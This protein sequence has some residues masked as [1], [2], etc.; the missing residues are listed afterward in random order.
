MKTGSTRLPFRAILFDLDNTLVELIDAKRHACGMVTRF[1]GLEDNGELF[2]YFRRAVHHFESHEHLRDYLVDR[3]L[4]GGDLFLRCMHIHE[5]EKLDHVQAYD[6]VAET[7]AYLRERGF[8]LA[9]VT[10]AYQEGARARL[11]RT[12]LLGYVDQLVT[13]EMTGRKK[14]DPSPFLLALELLE[15]LPEEAIIV[16]DS[17]R[18]EIAPGNQLGIV[19]AH[20]AYGDRNQGSIDGATPDYVLSDI[21]EIIRILHSGPP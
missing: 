16:G 1:I 12:G 13:T 19:T 3:G 9:V 6:G 18:R 17:L 7:L 21:R 5:E 11:E 14:P 4:T 10:D 15:V 8:R 20:A 2:E